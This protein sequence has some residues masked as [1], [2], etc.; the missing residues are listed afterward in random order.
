[1]IININNVIACRRSL[2]EVHFAVIPTKPAKAQALKAIQSLKTYIPIERARMKVR[3]AVTLPLALAAPGHAALHAVAEADAADE[4]EDGEAGD[5]HAAPPSAVAAA[6]GASK[7]AS[8][9]AAQLSHPSKLTASGVPLAV[10]EW[11]ASMHAVIEYEGRSDGSAPDDATTGTAAVEA[12]IDPGY[13]RRVEEEA[14]RLFGGIDGSRCSVEVLSLSVITESSMGGLAQGGDDAA[15]TGGE[16]QP[17]KSALKKG[18]N[19]SK[20]RSSRR[21]DDS[22]SDDDN[23]GSGVLGLPS[24]VSSMRVASDD[25]DE[26][27]TM[28]ANGHDQGRPTA[29]AGQAL[30]TAPAVAAPVLS[31]SSATAANDATMAAAK[32]TGMLVRRVT[33]PGQGRR[34]ACNACATEFETSDEHR[35]HHKSEWHRFNLK[36]KVKAMEPMSKDGFDGMPAKE[37]DAFLA[38]D[39]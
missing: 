30:A 26:D 38:M 24:K 34:L 25:E 11:L 15:P 21:G 12:I 17:K 32:G 3:V 20:A 33:Q 31:A 16:K 8:G 9:A 2:H 29:A 23:A 18:G 10:K 35:A 14:R 37:R 13:F 4:E 1:M 22:D 19:S 39:V 36:R 7:P 27:E 6:A 5:G 28:D